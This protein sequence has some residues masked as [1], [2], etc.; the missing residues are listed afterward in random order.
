VP[1]SAGGIIAA[2]VAAAAVVAAALF[3]GL[4]SRTPRESEHTVETTPSTPAQRV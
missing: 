1:H 2:S 3:L 4:R